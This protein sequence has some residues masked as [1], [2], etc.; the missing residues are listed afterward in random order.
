MK[1]VL[2]KFLPSSVR[3]ATLTRLFQSMLPED[4][5]GRTMGGSFLLTADGLACSR[6]MVPG[7]SIVVRGD[8]LLTFT[9]AS[10]NLLLIY[11][12]HKQLI[13]WRHCSQ[14]NF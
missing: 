11:I 1:N 13:P 12:Y 3:L 7:I 10:F 14:E 6:Y 8:D 4:V 9:T 5:S 2:M